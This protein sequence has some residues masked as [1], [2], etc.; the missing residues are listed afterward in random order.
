MLKYAVKEDYDNAKTEI[1]LLPIELEY[2]KPSKGKMNANF[3]NVKKRMAQ[4]KKQ[5]K[6]GKHVG[7]EN[8]SAEEDK[9][10]GDSE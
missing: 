8:S 9:E 1:N 5:N 10:A 2:I 3:A 6:K 4:R 7:Y